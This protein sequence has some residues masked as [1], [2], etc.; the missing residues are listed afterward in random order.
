MHNSLAAL[1]KFLTKSE[2]EMKLTRVL[3]P[4][5]YDGAQALL[6]CATKDNQVAQD[7]QTGPRVSVA[8]VRV[9]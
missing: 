8:S 3:P 5:D 7:D 1:L 2:G 4:S 6:L 9:R